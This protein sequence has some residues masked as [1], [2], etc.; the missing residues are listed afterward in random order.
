MFF[1]YG[2]C[3][4]HIFLGIKENAKGAFCLFPVMNDAD[5]FDVDGF[6]CKSGGDHSDLTGFVGDIDEE[7]VLFFN[8]SG[9]AVTHGIA[10]STGF[11]K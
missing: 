5:Y 3:S 11:F 6:G 2:D 9:T 8:R 7:A 4:F 1:Q 10:V